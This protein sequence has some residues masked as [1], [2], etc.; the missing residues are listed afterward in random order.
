MSFLQE[1]L[2]ESNTSTG[3]E[4]AS[5]SGSAARSGT[6]DASGRHSGRRRAGGGAGSTGDGTAASGVGSA[7]GGG[8]HGG[9]S[10]GCLG[11]ARSLGGGSLVGAGVGLGGR[12]LGGGSRRGRRVAVTIATNN[13]DALPVSRLVAVDV[14]LDTTVGRRVLASVIGDDN[15]LV[16]GVEGSL[17]EVGVTSSPLTGTLRR[18]FATSAPSSKLDLH[19][20]LGELSA[21]RVGSENTDTLAVNQPVNLL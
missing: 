8:G 3:H 6:R 19:R 1:E 17:G 20:S 4:S 14:L 5:N 18:V 16:V 11:R 9:L 7:S 12:S 2:D 10:V 21:N 15:A 13:L